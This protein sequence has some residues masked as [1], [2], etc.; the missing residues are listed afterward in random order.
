MNTLWD[1]AQESWETAEMLH[2]EDLY[3]NCV[4]NR[5]Y[6]A[7]FQATKWHNEQLAEPLK[8]KTKRDRNGT[9]RVVEHTH[10]FARRIIDET[11]KSVEHSRTFKDFKRF[12]IKADY[13]KHN[14]SK[15]DLSSYNI[16]KAQEL[17]NKLLK[18]GDNSQ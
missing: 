9:E 11:L 2:K 8:E 12:R 6:Y 7:L 4:A 3:L 17:L 15:H 13:K 5:F 10:E 18:T 1:K 16:S 14:V